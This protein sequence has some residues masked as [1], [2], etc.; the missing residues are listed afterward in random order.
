MY[1]FCPVNYRLPI[2]LYIYIN[3][4]IFI[5]SRWKHFARLW[6]LHREM[7]GLCENSNQIRPIRVSITQTNVNSTDWHSAIEDKT[8]ARGLL[9]WD[10]RTVHASVGTNSNKR[11]GRGAYT[12][13]KSCSNICRKFAAATRDISR[14]EGNTRTSSRGV[15]PLTHRVTYV[16]FS[17]NFSSV[18]PLYLTFHLLLLAND[19]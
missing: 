1:P 10:E 5:I 8:M 12:R 19:F 16:V 6:Y 11:E 17:P 13:H 14:L 9:R 4:S 7:F 3:R 15:Q 2:S 18:R